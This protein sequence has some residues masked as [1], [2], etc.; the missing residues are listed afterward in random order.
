MK[1][2][3]HFDCV[4]HFQTKVWVAA[5]VSNQGVPSPFSL[6]GRCRVV[7]KEFKTIV[8]KSPVA[9]S[10][11]YILGFVSCLLACLGYWPC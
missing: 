5:L 11:V 9:L 1:A 7:P 6:F 8:R 10:D 2:D 3:V 4:F